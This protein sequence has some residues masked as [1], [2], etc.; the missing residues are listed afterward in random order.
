M[1]VQEAHT[2]D[3]WR[4]G[5]VVTTVP[6]HKTL[7]DRLAAARAFVDKFQFRTLVDTAV[8][9]MDNHFN[10]R[11]SVWPERLVVLRRPTAGAPPVVVYI[12]ETDARGGSSLWTDE[13]EAYLTREFP[14]STTVSN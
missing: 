3:G 7:D 8:D 10:D 13:A 12:Q 1:Y 5:S 9:T 6:Q 2:T 4:L 11:Y 14:T